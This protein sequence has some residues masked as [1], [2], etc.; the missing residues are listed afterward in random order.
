M[1]APEFNDPRWHKSSHSNG[2]GG[3]CVE[4]AA[5]DE[6]MYARDSKLGEASGLVQYSHNAWTAFLELMTTKV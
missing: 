6:A 3:D 5:A 1:T 2:D 4:I